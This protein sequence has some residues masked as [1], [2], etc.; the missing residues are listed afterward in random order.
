MGRPQ[1]PGADA[2][3]TL[4]LLILSRLARGPMHGFGIAEYLHSVSDAL[5]VEEGSLYPALHRLE[6]QGVIESTWGVS[7]NNRKARF[8]SLTPRGRRQVTAKISDWRRMVEAINRV[9]EPLAP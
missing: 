8:Y 1:Q 6:S 7:E 3:G 5:H 4:D 2:I 9:I